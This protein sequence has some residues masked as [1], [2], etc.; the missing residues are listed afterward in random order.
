MS[1]R[2]CP[3][4]C[5]S[6][7]PESADRCSICVGL[8]FQWV[9]V[10]LN[11][12]VITVNAV[13]T[14]GVFDHFVP[15]LTEWNGWKDMNVKPARKAM[16]GITWLSDWLT[17]ARAASH[18]PWTAEGEVGPDPVLALVSLPASPHYLLFSYDLLP[19]HFGIE[20]CKSVR[21]SHAAYCIGQSVRWGF[22][23][24]HK[25]GTVSKRYGSN[26]MK[27]QHST[28]RGRGGEERFMEGRKG[29][30]KE[31][32]GRVEIFKSWMPHLSDKLFHARHCTDNSLELD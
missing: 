13:S 4:L 12:T 9:A 8:D 29:K 2:L 16:P 20:R 15:R 22:S 18:A 11:C 21:M 28:G 25:D 10:R 6:C 19:H 5:L 32:G 27:A 23:M 24:W 1:L 3:C 31:E 30:V 7:Y 17:S 26:W 14:Q